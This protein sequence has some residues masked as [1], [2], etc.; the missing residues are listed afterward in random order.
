MV[1]ERNR[2]NSQRARRAS[3]RPDVEQMNRATKRLYLHRRLDEVENQIQS[4]LFRY[5]S[6]LFSAGPHWLSRRQELWED[7]MDLHY[8]EASR[9]AILQSLADLNLPALSPHGLPD[10]IDADDEQGETISGIGGD[11]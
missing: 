5:L 8:L 1:G 7:V 11:R 10:N 9:R 4:S 3:M 6:D 2:T